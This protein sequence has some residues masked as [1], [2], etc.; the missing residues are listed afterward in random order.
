MIETVP[1]MNLE[2]HNERVQSERR[3]KEEEKKK[4]GERWGGGKKADGLSNTD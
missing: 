1:Q 2:P 4:K 3:E